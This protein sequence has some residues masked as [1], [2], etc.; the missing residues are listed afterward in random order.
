VTLDSRLY[1]VSL[2]TTKPAPE[3][4]PL[5]VLPEPD[6]CGAFSIDVLCP[7]ASDRESSYHSNSTETLNPLGY[8][9]IGLLS[10]HLFRSIYQRSSERHRQKA[11][12]ISTTSLP[13]ATLL[14]SPLGSPGGKHGPLR[15]CLSSADQPQLKHPW[16]TRILFS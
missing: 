15:F 10:P 7:F 11:P 12:T 16:V 1:F 5:D 14:T 2:P 3:P 4:V 13:S 6:S 9:H 8:T